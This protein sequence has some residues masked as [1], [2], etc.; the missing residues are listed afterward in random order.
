[1]MKKKGFTLIELLVTITIIA[2]LSIIA[3]G[4]YNYF[5]KTARDG[6][7][8]ADLKIIQSALEDYHA[9]QIYYPPT[10]TFGGPL[11]FGTKNYLNKIPNDPN[12]GSSYS[13]E[14]SGTS[15]CLFAN[16]EGIP[17]SSDNGCTDFPSG[18]DYGVTRP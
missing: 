18:Y 7:R 3:L 14:V 10:I 2:V 12:T 6:K 4:S 9:D 15:Y 13:Y 1:M 17:P 5:I 8:Q 11:T 16:M